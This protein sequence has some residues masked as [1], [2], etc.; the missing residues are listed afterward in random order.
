MVRRH[1]LYNFNP[2]NMGW[3]DRFYDLIYGLSWRK[4]QVHWGRKYISGRCVRC[5]M[6]VLHL[7][8]DSAAQIVSFL[9]SHHL[10]LP[11][12]VHYSIQYWGIEVSNGYHEWSIS[13]SNSVCFTSCISG[14]L[15][16]TPGP[17]LGS[18]EREPCGLGSYPQ[19]AEFPSRGAD[20]ELPTS[21]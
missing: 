11:S 14:S 20:V 4:V 10:V 3:G 1:S 8:G 16:N 21:L 12:T 13:P 18:Q 6:D 9:V 17:R 15:S 7:A 2:S 5:C 19:G